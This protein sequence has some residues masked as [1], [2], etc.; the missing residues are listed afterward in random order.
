MRNVIK[1]DPITPENR[2]PQGRHVSREQRIRGYRLKAMERKTKTEENTKYKSGID[3]SQQA[4][5][6]KTTWYKIVMT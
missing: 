6:T 1:T 5:P 3:Q 2:G 4:F